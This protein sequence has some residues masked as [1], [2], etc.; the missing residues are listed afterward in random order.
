M[1]KLRPKEKQ[2]LA[3]DGWGSLSQVFLPCCVALAQVALKEADGQ[4]PT[5]TPHHLSLHFC[6]SPNGTERAGVE[7]EKHTSPK[8][9]HLYP[10]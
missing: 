2:A 3:L 4:T 10:K 5:H 1:S 6:L 7:E 9:F 8:T